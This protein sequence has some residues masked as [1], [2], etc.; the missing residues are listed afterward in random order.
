MRDTSFHVREVAGGCLEGENARYR[1]LV[2][3]IS[4]S[5][6]IV[7]NPN[8]IKQSCD[9][10]YDKNVDPGVLINYCGRAGRVVQVNS[11]AD[12]ARLAFRT[13]HVWV[14]ISVITL[15]NSDPM[16]SIGCRNTT[17]SVLGNPSKSELLVAAKAIAK[18][19]DEKWK[20]RKKEREKDTKF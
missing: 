14:P 20:L 8:F 16:S 13:A 1:Q 17:I 2:S 11:A 4:K 12:T 15:C 9:N 10:C 7:D 5:V 3:M 19:E 18:R 6:L